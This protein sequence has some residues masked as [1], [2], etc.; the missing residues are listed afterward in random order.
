MVSAKMECCPEL[1][2]DTNHCYPVNG[3]NGGCARKR[4]LT[5]MTCPRTP[6][7]RRRCSW[8]NRRRATTGYHCLGEAPTRSWVGASYCCCYCCYCCCCCCCC[9]KYP[10]RGRFLWRRLLWR[11]RSW[12][13]RRRPRR[14]L[15]WRRWRQLR[16]RGHSCHCRCR[17]CHC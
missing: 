15:W 17:R 7:L 16:R 13:R 8:G 6:P 12:R 11:R 4:I 9:W 10:C 1:I 3:V 14:L 5:T 2:N